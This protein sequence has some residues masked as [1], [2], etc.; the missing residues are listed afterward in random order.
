MKRRDWLM[1]LALSI[2]WGGSYLFIRV[3]VAEITPLTLVFA[4]VTIAATALGIWLTA[5]G[6]HLPRGGRVWLAL[7]GMGLLNNIIPFSLIF[8]GQIE[9]GAGLAA[10]L[11]ATT[12]LFT[13]L[14][15]HVLTQD[16]KLSPA[17]IAGV[18]LGL[19][20]V[21]VMIGPQAL[22]GLDRSVAAQIACLGAALSYGLA[23]IYGRRFRTMPITPIQTAF[24][25]LA[26]SA[27][28]MLPIAAGIDRPWTM[29]PPGVAALSALCALALLS[30]A[31]AYI[32]FY[33]ILSSAG[34]TSIS[35]VTFLIPPGAI[36]LGAI[37]L[38]ER[39][40][41]RHIIGMACLGAGLAAIDGQIIRRIKGAPRDPQRAA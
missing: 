18:F 14:A 5:T 6:E 32:L 17:K 11:N 10:I 21:A 23:N 12:P 36:L 37:V 39:L 22:A 41:A 13:V 24:G 3:A 27:A 19:A 29:A 8:W 9:I 4:R 1:L 26:A 20:G 28:L 34:A 38:G 2:L 31:V 33:K 30:T 35:L 15:A 7:A 40:E 25:T 16:E